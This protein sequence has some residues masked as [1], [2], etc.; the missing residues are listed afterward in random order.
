MKTEIIQTIAAAEGIEI[1][2]ARISLG[3]SV[4]IHDTDADQYLPARIYS[5]LAAAVEYA[6]GLAA[7]M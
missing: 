2:V 6:T 5:T 3:Y 1:D 4:V 7:R